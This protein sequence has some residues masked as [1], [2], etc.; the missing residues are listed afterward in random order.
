MQRLWAIGIRRDETLPEE[1]MLDWYKFRESLLSLNNLFI[2]RCIVIP[3][4]IIDSQ[5]HGFSE[6][7]IEAFGACLYLITTNNEG[8]RSSRLICAKSRVAPLKSI[9]LQRLEL[10]GAVLLARLA[11]KIITKIKMNISQRTFWTDSSIVLA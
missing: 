1:T 6:A 4:Q 10:C 5:I 3:G 7:L 11:D 2:P 8:K 9:S